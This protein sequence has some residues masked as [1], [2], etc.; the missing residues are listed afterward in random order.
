MSLEK[1]YKII[2]TV[3]SVLLAISVVLLTVQFVR[4]AILSSDEATV[5]NNSIGAVEKDWLF[6]GENVLPGDSESKEYKIT[7][8][9]EKDTAV[10]FRAFI[11]RDEG[12][13]SNVLNLLVEDT[14]SG[15][16]VCQG[17]LSDIVDRDF[18]NIVT[19]DQNDEKTVTYK[20]T[21]TMD[22]AA[23]NEYQNAELAMRFR[24]SLEKESD[25]Q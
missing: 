8:R 23:G 1:K 16:I 25:G 10:A 7:F 3:L 24:W 12:N 15:K 14:S 5:K 20:I 21:V 17:K 18:S 4:K 6:K 11:D 19:Y 9:L 22:S 2:I 13:L